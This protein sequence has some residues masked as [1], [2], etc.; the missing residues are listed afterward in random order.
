MD[1]YRK[2]TILLGSLPADYEMIVTI[3]ENSTGLTLMDVIEKLLK[4]YEK[5]QQ[6]ETSEGAFRVHH[7]QGRERTMRQQPER[8]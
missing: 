8:L 1:E 7:G 2:M 5:N 6:K 3:L 4:D